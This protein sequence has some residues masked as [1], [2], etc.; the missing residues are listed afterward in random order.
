MQH[1]AVAWH[2]PEEMQLLSNAAHIVEG[3]IIGVIALLALAQAMGYAVSGRARLAWPGL[4]LFAG[5]FLLLYLLIPWHGLD[6]AV[7][8]WQYIFS[9][10]QQRQHLVIAVALTLA[11]VAEVLYLRRADAWLEPIFPLATLS[12]GV[13]FFVHTQHGTSEAVQRA[14]LIHQLLGVVLG[15][16]G[17]LALGARIKPHLR[18]LQF[19]WPLALLIAA[20]LLFVYREPAGAYH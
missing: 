2:T 5:V 8:Q 10:A 12:V 18:W 19:A 6:Q 20:L 4:V 15:S 14:V 1:G 9:D 7:A 16:A 3:A 13:A 17:V 11:G